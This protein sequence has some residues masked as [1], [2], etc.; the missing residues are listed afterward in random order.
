MTP[1]S[2]YQPFRPA[3]RPGGRP[4]LQPSYRVLVHHRFKNHYDQLSERVG[5]QGAQE[6]W[7]H[8]SQKPGSQPPTANTCIL[9]GSAGKPMGEGWSRTIHYE[10]SSSGRVDYQFND[11][12]CGGEFVDPHPVVAIMTI[13]YS[14]H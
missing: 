4:G 3:R 7:D 14:S 8:I 9:R 5:L 13:N 1:Q 6:L 2:A 12:F 11:A 10:V